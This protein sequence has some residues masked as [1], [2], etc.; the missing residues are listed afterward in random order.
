VWC[1]ATGMIYG[2]TGGVKLYGEISVHH[3]TVF[4]VDHS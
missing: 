1:T 3:I 2:K 4:S